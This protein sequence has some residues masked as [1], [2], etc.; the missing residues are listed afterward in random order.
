[1]LAER[2]VGHVLARIYDFLAIELPRA[3]F[4]L[5]VLKHPRNPGDMVAVLDAASKA[6]VDAA[7]ETLIH[8]PRYSSATLS[9]GKL[10]SYELRNGT[11]GI[12]AKLAGEAR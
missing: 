8:H 1:M 10:L 9:G 2:G 4:S 3:G 11:R 6:E 5:T 12:S 7:C